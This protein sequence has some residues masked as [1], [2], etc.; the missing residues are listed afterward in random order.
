MI[1]KRYKNNKIYQK[2]QKKM[3][4]QNIQIQMSSRFTAASKLTIG[5]FASNP[6]FTLLKKELQKLQLL[7]YKMIKKPTDVPY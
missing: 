4:R 6:S 1:L 2:L 7:R 5:T 3:Q